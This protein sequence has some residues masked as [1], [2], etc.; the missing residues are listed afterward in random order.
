MKWLQR[1]DEFPFSVKAPLPSMIHGI[2]KTPYQQ[3]LGVPLFTQ[4]ACLREIS[5]SEQKPKG[6]GDRSPGAT[7]SGSLGKVNVGAAAM[8]HDWT[9][10]DH[11]ILPSQKPFSAEAEVLSPYLGRKFTAVTQLTAQ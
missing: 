5:R 3:Y 6:Q 11:P 8:T 10:V 1:N 9:L 7:R 2:V 4:M